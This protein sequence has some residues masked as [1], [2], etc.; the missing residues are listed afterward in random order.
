[1]NVTIRR[2]KPEDAPYLAAAIS[3]KKVLNNLRDGLPYPYTENDAADYINAMLAADPDSTYAYAID[4]DGTAVGSIGAFRQSNIHFRTAELGYYLSENYWGKGVMTEAVRQLCRKIF[5]ETDILRIYAEPFA[6]NSG[7]R[8]VLEKAGFQFEGIM[9][10]NAVKNGQVLDMALYAL[11]RQTERYPV[12]RLYADEIQN[13]LDLTWEVFLQYEAPEYSQEGID[14]FR[15]SL[16]DKERTRNLIFYGAFCG[17]ELVGTL[18][19]REP[20]HIG[21]FFVAADYQG[22]GIVRALFETM[23]K[24]YDNQ[25]FTVNSSPH[26]VKIYEHMGF[27]AT[28]T[29]QLV[30]GLRYTPMIYGRR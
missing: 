6:Y 15:A 13:A 18:C 19:M 29:E 7:S 28:D 27:V 11:T 21:G 2:W 4:I 25:Q 26:A 20:Q 9:K 30:D 14:F 16:D 12:R 24:D 8:R 3:N 22:K 17:S 23:R 5:D 1:M 10:N